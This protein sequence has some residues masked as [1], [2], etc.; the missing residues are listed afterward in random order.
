VLVATVLTALLAK[1]LWGDTGRDSP[2]FDDL[3]RD[4]AAEG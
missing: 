3:V 4:L 1:L 2:V